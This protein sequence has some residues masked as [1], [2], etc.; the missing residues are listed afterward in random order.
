[1]N[2]SVQILVSSHLPDVFLHQIDV[3][4]DGTIYDCD[5]N[6]GLGLPVG[7]GIPTHLNSF[8]FGF[9]LSLSVID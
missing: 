1:M 2:D 9:E 8:D 7:F 4:W 5:L 6:L 3:G